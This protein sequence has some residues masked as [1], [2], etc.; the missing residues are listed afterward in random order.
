MK[1][2]SF[3]LPAIEIIPIIGDADNIGFSTEE[4]GFDDFD[5]VED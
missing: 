5:T 1:K 4:F 3:I 2:K